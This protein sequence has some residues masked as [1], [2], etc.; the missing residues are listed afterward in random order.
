MLASNTILLTHN[1]WQDLQ[2]ELS[3]LLEGRLTVALSSSRGLHY[4]DSDTIDQSL[5]LVE[6]RIDELRRILLIATPVR[7]EDVADGIVGIGSCVSVR[8]DDG[9]GQELTIVGPPEVA[10]REGRISYESPVGH[11]LMGCTAGDEVLVPMGDP[12]TRMTVV[13]VSSGPNDRLSNANL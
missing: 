8:W 2:D 1:G 10:P 11:A 9:E 7:I 6:E 5:G 13:A 4:G 12:T 3:A